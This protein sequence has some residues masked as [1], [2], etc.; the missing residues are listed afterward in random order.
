MRKIADANDL[1]R[2][3]RRLLAY[4]QSAKPSRERIA[5]AL[6]ELSRRTAGAFDGVA[7]A[8]Y[9]FF[10]RAEKLWSTVSYTGGNGERGVGEVRWGTLGVVKFRDANNDRA[11]VVDVPAIYM[12]ASPEQVV[13]ALNAIAKI[14]GNTSL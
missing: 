1:E 5:S 6:Q 7:S 13:K 10:L 4:S 11:V 2:E 12:K 3:L 9:E 14:V 8:A